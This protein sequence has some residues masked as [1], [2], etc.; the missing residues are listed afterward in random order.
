M[1]KPHDYHG[2]I[3]DFCGMNHDH[4]AEQR[5]IREAAIEQDLVNEEYDRRFREYWIEHKVDAAYVVK[6]S[7]S[8]ENHI[9]FTGTYA[10]CEN[11]I[12]RY[13]N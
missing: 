2:E 12:S 1:N 13:K 8:G 9:D 6:Y 10:E 7:A 3:S 5:Q 11:F 4:E